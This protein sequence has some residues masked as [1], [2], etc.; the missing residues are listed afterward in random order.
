MPHDDY[1]QTPLRR[2]YLDTSRP[3]SPPTAT[4]RPLSI[5]Q[6]VPPWLPVPPRGYG[7]IEAV[8]ATL[9]DG[10]VARGHHVELVAGGGLQVPVPLHA[11]FPEP[12]PDRINDSIVD[13]LHGAA[14]QEIAMSRHFDVIHEHTWLGA[15]LGPLRPVPTLTT[16]HNLPSRDYLTYTEIVSKNSALVGLSRSHLSGL[17]TVRWSG[18][19]H[20]GIPT[21]KYPFSPE[22]A[23][24]DW[25]FYLGRAT[26]AKGMHAAIDA[27]R[28][29]GRRI[30]L[31]A[32]CNEPPEKKYFAEYIAPRLGRD[33]C[34][35]P[36]GVP[37]GRTG[38]RRDRR[39][40]SR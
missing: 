24:E 29:A 6:V 14:A 21:D 9:V 16:I 17:P 27:A 23:R 32:K 39:P 2:R 13:L 28:A 30:I 15:L 25:V 12:M 26:R 22:S 36:P 31:A 33:N 5:L 10:L 35:C 18:Y 34:R 3:E 20:N 4:L 7:G 19:V 37:P 11:A 40:G 8:C 1:P 38:S